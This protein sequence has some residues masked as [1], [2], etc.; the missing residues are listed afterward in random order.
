MTYD[1]YLLHHRKF[2]REHNIPT[3]LAARY[4]KAVE[5][6]AELFRAYDDY[7]SNKDGAM[8]R[9]KDEAV[10]RLITG[11]ALCESLGM[12]NIL[13]ACFDKLERVRDRSEYREMR[14]STIG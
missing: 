11:F 6:D 7:L 14:E 13:Q 8:E 5:E 4:A 12:V 10:D 1:L 9:M 2:F 3:S